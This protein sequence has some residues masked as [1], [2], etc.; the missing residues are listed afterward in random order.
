MARWTLADRNIESGTPAFIRKVFPIC[1]YTQFS[2]FFAVEPNSVCLGLLEPILSRITALTPVRNSA[3][4]DT[5]AFG[6]VDIL[7]LAIHMG[8]VTHANV[9]AGTNA[10]TSVTN[11]VAAAVSIATGSTEKGSQAAD[12]ANV[13]KA[14]VGVAQGNEVSNPAE[15]ASSL[16]R[17]W[18]CWAS[19]I[20][21]LRRYRTHSATAASTE[22]A[23][24]S[25]VL[26]RRS[27][28]IIPITPKRFDSGEKNDGHIP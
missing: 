16:S 8:T 12:L 22:A 1:V 11:P 20:N 3:F 7:R 13:V 17:S 23:F 2:H 10:V 25:A 28:Q 5:I 18:S 6:I 19:E 4:S 26:G 14:G 27:L 9:D 15:A 24:S 21:H